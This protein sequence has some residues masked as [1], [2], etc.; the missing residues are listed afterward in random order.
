MN[1]VQ[2][3][4]NPECDGYSAALEMGDQWICDSPNLRILKFVAPAYNSPMDLILSLHTLN[5]FDVSDT[6]YELLKSNV[7]YDNKV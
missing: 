4:N 5:I 6:I 7:I 2:K 1:K 3:H